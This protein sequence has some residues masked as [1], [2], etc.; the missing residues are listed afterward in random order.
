[1]RLQIERQPDRLAATVRPVLRCCLALALIAFWTD[2]SHAQKP[3]PNTTSSATPAL[4]PY[5]DGLYL[6]FSNLWTQVRNRNADTFISA[7]PQISA[8]QSASLSETSADH[9]H[10]DACVNAL[11]RANQLDDQ[12]KAYFSSNHSDPSPAQVSAGNRLVQQAMALD[13][14]NPD[15]DAAFNWFNTLRN[16]DLFA[17]GSNTP[18]NPD[19]FSTQSGPPLN[20]G[21]STGGGP[22]PSQPLRS[23]GGYNTC[24]N[25]TFPAEC[26]ARFPGRIFKCWIDMNGKNICMI[27]G[28]KNGI[29]SGTDQSPR[30]SP[31]WR[32]V[33]TQKPTEDQCSD[34]SI[35]K[36]QD[37]RTRELL[38]LL[39]NHFYYPQDGHVL[40][41]LLK[42]DI[43]VIGPSDYTYNCYGFAEGLPFGP[44]RWVAK[45]GTPLTKL[46]PTPPSSVQWVDDRDDL[47]KAFSKRWE[48]PVKYDQATI[49]KSGGRW[50]VFYGNNLGLQHVAV[51]TADGVYAKMGLFGTFRFKTLDQMGGG[52]FG[53]P[54]TMMKY[55][56][57]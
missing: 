24:S 20:S 10:L 54:V 11:L 41:Q 38:R 42:H 52:Y 49:E 43:T 1:V 27:V 40:P 14:T 5:N 32:V 18:P 3:P 13:N 34:A 12:A 53:E 51:W 36:I 31:S 56:G 44:Y 47:Y 19:T 15:C 26:K 29:G 16:S 35:L 46:A 25:P 4:E 55:R 37:M 23:S 57:M 9:Q 39:C 7:A 17:S 21:I 45:R 30:P 28:F 33:F 22:S 48:P 2:T 50:A 8:W 6:A